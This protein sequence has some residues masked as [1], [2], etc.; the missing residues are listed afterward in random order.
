MARILQTPSI[1]AIDS[2][3][4]S[5]DRDID[6]YYEDNQPYKHRIVIINNQTNQTNQTVYDKTIESMRKYIT[7]PA[8]TL[9][10]GVQYLI[11]IQ[12]FDV[13]GNKSNLSDPVLFYCFS[14]P[15][16]NFSNVTNEQIY[17]NASIELSLTYSQ[18]QNEQIKD[19]QFILYSQDKILLTSSKVFYSST[20]SSYTFYGLQNNTKYYVRAY[21][22][23]INGM[24]M[25]TGYVAINI[26]Y[27]RIPANIGF[28]IQNIYD[29]GY[30]SIETN[31]L[32]IGYETENDN[33]EFVDGCLILKNN[34][35]TYNEGF[36]ITGDFSLFIEAKK[37][38]ISKFFTVGDGSISLNIVKICNTYYCRLFVKDSSLVMCTALPKARITTNNGEYIITEDGKTI[39]IINTSYDDNE[40][41]VFELKRVKGIYSLNA[42]Y[43]QERMVANA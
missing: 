36:E 19:Y 25:D 7:I 33:Y 34:S 43:K 4:P 16:L 11:Q 32:S 26:Q 39:E 20:L 5:Y 14:I 40:L 22:E 37:L 42:Y 10:G 28:Y 31:I 21:G 17:R 6:F 15:I 1:A 35:L 18:A 2:F 24:Q 12:V 23:T 13:D 41:V 29:K 38:P 8:K 3:D 27:E 30:I 9:T